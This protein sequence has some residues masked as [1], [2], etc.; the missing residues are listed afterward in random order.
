MSFAPM[1][2][3]PGTITDRRWTDGRLS[4]PGIRRDVLSQP[5]GIG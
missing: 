4:D 2:T 1:T 5:P 3:P